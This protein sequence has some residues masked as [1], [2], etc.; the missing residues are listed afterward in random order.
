M[1]RYLTISTIGT[2][3]P[4]YSPGQAQ[5]QVKK[6]LDFWD[7]KLDCVLPDMPDL[8]VLPEACD[9]YNGM[10]D[11]DRLDYYAARGDK[12]LNFFSRKAK[13]NN[14]YIAY[15]AAFQVADGT[16]RNCTQLIDRDGEVAGIYNKNH[17]VIE[18]TT[19]YGILCGKNAD[20][21]E[22]D[23]GTVACAICFDLNFEELRLKYA[24]A[25]PD[26]ILFSSMY[27]GG[28]MQAYWAYSCRAHFVGAV[29]NLPSAIL[30]PNGE[31]LAET[32]NYFDY[33]T[34]TVNLDCKLVHL[35]YNWEKISAAKAKYGRGLIIKDPGKLGNVLLS[36]ELE[37]LDIDEI[38]E[39]FEIETLDDYM[40]RALQHRH[41]PGNME[42]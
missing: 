33:V 39:E 20:L 13:E 40:A 10:T 16:F 30:S 14:C 9:R 12:M 15:S 8:I 42:K 19:E 37:D 7:R 27:H 6:M 26:L 2:K 17:V 1:A 11:K 21:I 32:T 5:E 35:D 4:E 36:S 24:A 38:I 25:K 28:L 31:I 23:F 34:H 18:E 29:Q 41:T 22:T 3:A